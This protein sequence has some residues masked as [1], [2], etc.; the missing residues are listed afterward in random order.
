MEVLNAIE[1]IIFTRVQQSTSQAAWELKLMENAEACVF[2]CVCDI[3]ICS[4]E[5]RTQ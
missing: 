2:V 4:Q 5:C 3:F 1:A